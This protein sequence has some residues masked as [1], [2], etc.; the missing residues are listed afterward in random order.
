MLLVAVLA[1]RP[2]QASAETTAPAF[3]FKI[4]VHTQN[5][6]GLRRTE[7][8]AV[9]LGKKSVWK[10]GAKIVP[11]LLPEQ[12]SVTRTFVREVVRKSLGQYRAYW[13]RRLFS[14]GGAAPKTL[15]SSRDVVEFVA[16]NPGAIGVVEKSTE[17][18]DERIKVVEIGD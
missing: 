16:R 13:K 3:A 9:Y 18:D 8:A 15:P 14:G 11:V 2:S 4:I 5:D 7:L 10:S 6:E 17:V 1:L 12:G